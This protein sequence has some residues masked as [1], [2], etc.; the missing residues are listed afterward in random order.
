MCTQ[1]CWTIFCPPDLFKRL[2]DKHINNIHTANKNCKNKNNIQT[3]KENYE[4]INDRKSPCTHVHPILLENIWNFKLR[5]II[6]QISLG[7]YNTPNKT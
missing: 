3:N 7:I 2:K 1:Y 6:V 4:D 5:K